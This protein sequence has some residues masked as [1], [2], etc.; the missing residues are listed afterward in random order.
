MGSEASPFIRVSDK[1]ATQHTKGIGNKQDKE[2]KCEES[3]LD[4]GVITKGVFKVFTGAKLSRFLIGNLWGQF[5]FFLQV[6]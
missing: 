4:K 6:C 3:G 5:V 2:D 1:K